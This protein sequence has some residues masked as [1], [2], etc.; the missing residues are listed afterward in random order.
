MKKN[1]PYHV[2]ADRERRLCALR[3]T[4]EGNGTSNS[5]IIRSVFGHYGLSATDA[6]VER[7]LRWLAEHGFV[8][9]TPVADGMWRVRITA[10]G[11]ELAEGRAT[12]P[13]V[14]PLDEQEP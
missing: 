3:A 7:T 11:R 6:T 12:H 14:T 2:F 5:S 1:T 8:D 4:A 13:D 9:L 10:S